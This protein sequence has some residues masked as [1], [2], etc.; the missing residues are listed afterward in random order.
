MDAPNG[1]GE[2]YKT[3]AVSHDL[4]MAVKLASVKGGQSMQSYV[5]WALRVAL[6]D[7]GERVKEQQCTL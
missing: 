7:K 1:N 3:I 5:E 4:H 2:R 6:E